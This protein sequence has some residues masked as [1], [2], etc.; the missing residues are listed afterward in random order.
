MKLESVGK[1]LLISGLSELNA[2]NAGHFRDR[3]R[4]AIQ[5]EHSRVDL[6]LS[7]TRFVDSSGLG[8]LIALN[9]LM[10][11]RQGHVRIL[12]PLPAVLQILELTR[13]H[14]VFEIAKN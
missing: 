12:N 7:M 9:K 5:P 11:S 13:M 1:T 6:D 4:A 10:N 14:R 2:A 3:A 8:A